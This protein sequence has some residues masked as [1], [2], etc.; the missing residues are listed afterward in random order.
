MAD[1]ELEFLSGASSAYVEELYARFLADPRSVES[2]WREFFA[3]LAEDP[4]AAV[5]RTQGASWARPLSLAVEQERR[6]VGRGRPA[7]H[8][9]VERAALWAIRARMMI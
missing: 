3:G 6:K 2:G 8:D 5:A 1:R 7:G 9:D 4:R